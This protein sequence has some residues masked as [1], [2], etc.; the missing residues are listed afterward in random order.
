MEEP[1]TELSIAYVGWGSY[2]IPI[3]I[4]FHP[5]TGIDE[6]YEYDHC[7]HFGGNGRWRTETIDIGKKKW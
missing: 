5:E 4:T 1:C 3:E 7:L 6:V 2:N